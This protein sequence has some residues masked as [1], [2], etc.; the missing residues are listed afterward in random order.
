MSLPIDGLRDEFERC[1]DAS[2]RLVVTAETGAGKSTRVPVWLAERFAQGGTE[3]LI[4][5]VEPRRVAC[6]ALAEFLSSQRGESVGGYFGSRVRFSDRSGR[7]TRVLFCTPGVALRM[8]ADST[9]LPAAIVVDEFHERSWQMDLVVAGAASLPR[10]REVPLVLTSATLDAEAVARTLAATTLN[11]TGRTF[12]VDVQYERG[13]LEPHGE[14]IGPR[15]AAAVDRALLDHEG[16]VLVF[17]PGMREI[18]AVDSC[19]GRRD[20]EILIVHGSQSPEAMRRVFQKSRRRRIY[21]STNVAETS[22]TLPGVRV[23]IDSGL[24]KM[25]V[26]RGGRTVLATVAISDASMQQRAG[27]AGRVAAGTCIRLWSERFQPDPYLR[28][29]IE[30][31][32][33][34]DLLLQAAKVGLK[35]E[36]F[37]AANWV[38]APPDFA[39]QRA[40]ARLRSLAAFDGDTLTDRGLE[41]ASLPVS[42]FEA[43]LLVGSPPPIDAT[44]CDL[45]AIL[46]TGR[47][48]R[49]LKELDAQTRSR[50]Q[51]ARD[52]L[53]ARAVD[54]VTTNLVLLR[55]GVA[56][57]HY[58][59]R[60]RLDEARSIS[61]QLRGLVGATGESTRGLAAYLLE[62]LPSVGF[63]KRPRASK[64]RGRSEPWAN[65]EIEVQV[66]PFSPEAS[67]VA[68]WKA[69]AAVILEVDWVSSA[70]GVY[71]IGRMILPS[72]PK[73]LAAAGL[74]ERIVTHVTLDRR[75]RGGVEISATQETQLAGVTLAH[76]DSVLEGAELRQ[77]VAGLVLENRLF[78]GAR[79]LVRDALHGWDVLANW[80]GELVTETQRADNPAPEEAAVWLAQRLAELGVETCEDLALVDTADLLPDLAKE[81][82][83][84]DWE[85][86]PILQSLP[87]L[88]RYQGGTYSCTVFSRTKTVLLEPADA[89][90]KKAKEPPARVL[91]RFHGFRVNYKQGSRRRKLR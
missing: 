63:V 19:L 89:K 74:G 33:L 42:A 26:H 67:G 2:S 3:G 44:L 78:K 38:T 43:S 91:P 15:A 71:G 90:A 24:A 13:S 56:N 57:T 87:R 46:Q 58:L 16:D 82:G 62:R 77:A 65:G 18:R 83:I 53:L 60:R 5:V 10:F 68:P 47:L 50:V 76:D 9:T 32:E 61:R 52:E 36:A 86:K 51:E 73:V 40:L 75:S 8:L 66:F 81:T 17:L 84:P 30:R 39:V 37:A 70:K 64:G 31:I 54:E 41:L 35:G 69:N 14:E 4:L 27:R 6:H 48:L 80:K 59:S 34:D 29:E 45:V 49:D 85:S 79:D 28:P 55:A 20:E 25:Q 72:E 11:A 21:L 7:E 88:F 12:P 22:I 23:V 1:L